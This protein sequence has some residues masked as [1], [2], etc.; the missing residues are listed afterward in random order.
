MSRATATSY[1]EESVG[2]CCPPAPP[3]P[4]PPPSAAVPRGAPV[5]RQLDFGGGDLDLNDDDL[6]ILALDDIERYSE[7]KRR[8]PPCVCGRGVCAVEQGGHGRLMYVC[9]SRPKCKHIALCEE[10]DLSPKPQPAFRS[11]LKP[12]NPCVF[13]VPSNHITDARTPI[14]SINQQGP[15]VTSPT[16]VSPQG[17]VIAPFNA[18]SRGAGATTP[19]NFSPQGAKATAPVKVSPQG[20]KA[21]TPVKVSSQGAGS[22]S[23]TPICQCTA[24]KCKRARVGNVD[25]YV[26]PIPKGKGACS[27]KVPVNPV[28]KEANGNNLVQA[29]DNNANGSVN[30][31]QPKDDE[32]PFDIINNEIVPTARATPSNEVRQESPSM[33]HQP[34]DVV[35]TPTKSPMPPYVTRSPRTPC[36]DDICFECGKK[37]HWS[38]NCP[39]PRPCFHCGMVGHWKGSCP[40]LLDRRGS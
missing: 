23:A 11:H 31:A 18:T 8:A 35:K 25:Y 20:A 9:P 21:T 39:K 15:D 24:G 7:A 12:S 4:A 22:N 38:N 5:R 14:N 16:N 30:P 34:T 33:L 32:W 27:H 19:V 40:L 6:L 37:G 2:S 10:V 17:A 13:S 29:G 28:E 3:T 1:D 36:S 26:C